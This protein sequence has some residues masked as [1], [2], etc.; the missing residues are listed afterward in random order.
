[1]FLGVIPLRKTEEP[2]VYFKVLNSSASRRWRELG[3]FSRWL[4]S[5]SVTLP[6]LFPRCALPYRK[7]TRAVFYSVLLLGI[8][9]IFL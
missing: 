4:R 3:A 7:I 8:T 5:C 9:F 1:L 2:N 6:A